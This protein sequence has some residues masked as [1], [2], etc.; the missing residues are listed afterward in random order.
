VRIGA[1]LPQTEIGEVPEEVA[2][3]ALAVEDAGLTHLDLADHVLGA[4]PLGHP[5][6]DGVYDVDSQFHEP[7]VLFG[8]LAARTRSIELSTS[9]L[10]LPQRQTALVAK[11]AAE[12]DLLSGGRLRLGVGIGWNR[13][14]Y[15]ALGIPFA[16]RAARYEEQIELLRLLWTQRSVTYAGRFEHVDAA[17]IRPLPARRPI[18]V[19]MGGGAST[20]VLERIGRLGDGWLCNVLPGPALDEAWATVRRAAEAAG[21]DPDAIGLQGGVLVGEQLDGDRFRRH[22]DKWGAAG[23]THVVI[24]TDGWRRSPAE[25]RAVIHEAGTLAADH[26]GLRLEDTACP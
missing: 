9:V 12:A 2:G 15:D 6:W 21:R 13:V 4:D 11:Q 10:V 5:G 1:I 17:G 23:A 26:V 18:P 8:F 3:F 20:P 14:E 22:L 25:H 7:F 16:E 24:T 19:W